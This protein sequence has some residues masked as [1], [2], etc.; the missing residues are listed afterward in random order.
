MIK[1]LF[2]SIRDL[3]KRY[4][5]SPF[6][7]SACQHILRVDHISRDSCGYHVLCHTKYL[8][9][10][11]SHMTNVISVFSNYEE[12]DISQS[13]QVTILQVFL[14]LLASKGAA[15]VAGSSTV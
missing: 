6:S 3:L 15:M 10:T 11:S 9:Y 5:V 1:S 7:F 13:K 8:E 12:Y 4:I 2:P 14:I